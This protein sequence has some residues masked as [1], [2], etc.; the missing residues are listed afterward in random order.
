MWRHDAVSDVY[1]DDQLRDEHAD[2]C[3]DVHPNV[4]PNGSDTHDADDCDDVHFD[5]YRDDCRSDCHDDVPCCPPGPQGPPGPPGPSGGPPGP[6]GPQGAPGAQ[7]P[8]GPQGNGGAIGPIGPQGIQGDTGP[9]GPQGLVGPQGPQGI[10]G[11][12]GV[13]GPQ[14]DT[15]PIGP[16]GPQGVQGDTGPAG[17]AVPVVLLHAFDNLDQTVP[18]GAAVDFLPATTLVGAIAFDTQ[19]ITLL[20]PGTYEV[21]YGLQVDSRN[22]VGSAAREFGA[23]LNP[24]AIAVPGS[25]HLFHNDTADPGAFPGIVLETVAFMFTTVLPNQTLHIENMSG[26]PATLTADS[27]I[28]GGD[29]SAYITV[30]RVA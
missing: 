17:G 12:Q 4:H 5:D 10:Q 15:G 22:A 13:A 25:V 19:T 1:A 6:M 11:P 27:A 8:M 29:L 3:G 20:N 21:I 18:P 9:A 7:G 14:G 26:V 23:R 24:G 28:P 16:Q 30:K 2:D